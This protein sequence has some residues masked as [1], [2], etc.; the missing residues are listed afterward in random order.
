MTT[1]PL[2]RDV[3]PGFSQALTTDTDTVLTVPAGALGLVLWF[4]DAD[5]AIVGGRV[6]IDQA[7]TLV[8]PID[9]ENMGWHPPVPVEYTLLGYEQSGQTYR[10]RDNY[11]HVATS[12]TGITVKGSWLFAVDTG[13]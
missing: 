3:N 6:G 7:N 5:G 10:Y 9:D 4:E 8:D 11:V 12:G 2:I 13:E 1:L